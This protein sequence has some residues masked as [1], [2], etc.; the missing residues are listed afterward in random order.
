[1]TSLSDLY[2]TPTDAPTTLA[3][4]VVLGAFGYHALI[5]VQQSSWWMGGVVLLTGYLTDGIARVGW[6]FQN[7]FIPAGL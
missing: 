2:R 3:T 1:M 5:T 4:T 6:R 7:E